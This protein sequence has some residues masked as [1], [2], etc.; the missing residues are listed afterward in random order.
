[1]KMKMI[2]RSLFFSLS[3]SSR[4][5]PSVEK[6]LLTIDNDRGVVVRMFGRI[7]IRH[8][9][10]I[11]CRIE[12]DFLGWRWMRVVVNRCEM[13]MVVVMRWMGVER[14]VFVIVT[15]TFVIEIGHG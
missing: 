7:I 11:R 6:I 5:V 2:I 14:F 13:V 12:I 8:V 15:K 4:S 10:I 1:M 9:T 3:E